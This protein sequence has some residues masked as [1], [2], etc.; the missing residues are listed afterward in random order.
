MASEKDDGKDEEE[1]EEEE[2]EENPQ[3][4]HTS[5]TLLWDTSMNIAT[6]CI[7]EMTAQ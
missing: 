6:C 3:I 7:F 1:E 5:S 2:E 4:K